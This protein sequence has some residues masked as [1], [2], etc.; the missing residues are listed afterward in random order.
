MPHKVNP[1]DFENSEGN[2]GVANALLHHLAEKLPVSRWQRDLTDSTV[3]RNVGVALAHSLI[4]YE[5]TLRGIARLAVDERKVEADLESA[6]GVLAEA[7]QTVLRRYGIDRPYERL[8]EL[9]RGKSIDAAALHRFIDG[10][11]LPE[12]V[13]ARLRRLHPAGYTGNAAQQARRIASYDP[14]GRS[15]R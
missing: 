8:K 3:L 7:V 2:L 13:K 4:A 1:I 11:A 5:S 15:Y 6:W 10:L 12:E 14:T 9:T